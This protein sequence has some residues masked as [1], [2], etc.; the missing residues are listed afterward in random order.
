MAKPSAS[1]ATSESDEPTVPTVPTEPRAFDEVR[2]FQALDA[3]M[4]RSFTTFRKEMVDLSLQ[5]HEKTRRHVALVTSMTR[6][7]WAEVFGKDRPP[8]GGDGGLSFSLTEPDTSPGHLKESRPIP[9]MTPPSGG[10]I[11]EHD[12]TLASFH[13]QLIAVDGKVETVDAKVESLKSDVAMLTKLQKEQMGLRDGDDRS[14]IRR[15]ADGAVWIVTNRAGRKFALTLIAALTSLITA[16]GTTYALATGR[17][18]MPNNS[19]PALSSPH[20]P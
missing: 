16:A 4:D 2:F 9:P 5:E 19:S 10:K 18:P 14:M 6:A 11:S 7:L 3:H 12:A 1:A 8:P 17:L 20:Q 15:L 13:G